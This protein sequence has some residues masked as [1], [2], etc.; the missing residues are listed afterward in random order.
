[1]VGGPEKG[2]RKWRSME[3]SWAKTLNKQK[4][5]RVDCTKTSILITGEVVSGMWKVVLTSRTYTRALF[6]VCMLAPS[7]ISVFVGKENECEKYKEERAMY[8]WS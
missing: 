8:G 6:Y 4:G 3:A 5:M 2:C 1:M 7:R